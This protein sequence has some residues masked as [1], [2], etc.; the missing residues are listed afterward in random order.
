M[1]G[2]VFP[3]GVFLWCANC[4]HGYLVEEGQD[5][6]HIMYNKVII[7]QD[8]QKAAYWLVE[9][10]KKPPKSMALLGV[11][12]FVFILSSQIERFLKVSDVWP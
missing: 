5:D 6:R 4:E 11:L 1:W 12:V 8:P 7:Y 10:N 2:D 3:D 9:G